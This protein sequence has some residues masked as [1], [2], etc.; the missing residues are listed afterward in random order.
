MAASKDNP[1][2]SPSKPSNALSARPGPSRSSSTQTANASTSAANNASTAAGNASDWP[3]ETAVAVGQN[4]TGPPPGPKRTTS[5]T[6]LETTAIPTWQTASCYADITTCSSITTTGTSLVPAA[7]TGSAHPRTSTR[8]RHPARCP[9][10]P[11]PSPTSN[12]TNEGNKANECNR[13]K[14]DTENSSR[15]RGRTLPADQF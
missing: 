4:A 9:T 5:T 13:S 10:N 7:S 1:P 15:A 12:E 8:I 6:G 14:R 2:P 11:L 3:P